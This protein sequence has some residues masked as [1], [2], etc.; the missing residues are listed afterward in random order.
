M[1]DHDWM[2]EF[3]GDITV[4]D[5]SGVILELNAHAARTF[6]DRGGKQLIGTNLLDC[7]PEPSRSKLQQ[8]LDSQQGNS[9][10]VE[11]NGVKKFVHQAPWYRN[12]EFAGLVEIVVVIPDPLPTVSRDT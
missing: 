4:C 3:P 9:Y 5:P 11:K 8:M 10:T 12:G 2:E 6:Q 1:T 7:H